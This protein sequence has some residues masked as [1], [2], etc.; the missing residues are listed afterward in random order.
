MNVIRVFPRRTKATPDDQHAFVGWPDMFVEA[1]RVDISVSFDSDLVLAEQLADAWSQ[2]ASVTIGGPATE[3]NDP[4]SPFVPG[5]F[6]KPGYVITSRGCPR[7]CWF[8]KVGSREGTRVTELAIADGFNVLDSNLLACSQGHVER[9]F[10][11]L[12]R[13]ARPP[14]FTGGIDVRLLRAWHCERMV[15]LKTKTIWMAYDQTEDF[16]PLRR[17]VELLREHE[18]IDARNRCGCYVLCGFPGDTLCSAED[19]LKSV[20]RMGL[21]TQAMLYEEGRRLPSEWHR[22][23]WKRLCREYSNPVIVG[24][25]LKDARARNN[26]DPAT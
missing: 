21:R 2:I 25:K 24:S 3:Q 14:E 11:M 19:R 15:R 26:N 18:L 12:S 1:D 13:Q 22:K 5:R 23:Q 17:A 7:R 8:C 10:D 20:I 4:S 6:L 16:E 9:V